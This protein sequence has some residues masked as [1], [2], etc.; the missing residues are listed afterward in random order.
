[1]T[2]GKTAFVVASRLK[3]K[4]VV[5]YVSTRC[6]EFHDSTIPAARQ[7]DLFLTGLVYFIPPFQLLSATAM[8]RRH[9]G[10]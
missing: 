6:L 10:A 7:R 5:R 1:V 9:G 3:A 8:H 4:K 2:E